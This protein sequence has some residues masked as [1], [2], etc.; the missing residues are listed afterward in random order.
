MKPGAR[1]MDVIC[2]SL[3]LS[4]DRIARNDVMY[5]HA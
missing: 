4:V 2:Y 5:H 1:S 3:V